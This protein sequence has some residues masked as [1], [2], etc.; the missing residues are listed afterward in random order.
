MR[1]GRKQCPKKAPKEDTKKPHQPRG[2]RLKAAWNTGAK[3]KEKVSQKGS[4]RRHQNATPAPWRTFENI[5]ENRCEMEG[6]S[7]PKRPQRRHQKA[8]PAS[9]RAF[10]SSL[11]NR[12]EILEISTPL[13]RQSNFFLLFV[14]RSSVVRI[15]RKRGPKKGAL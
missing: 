14:S 15:S 10:E 9:W 3:W 6:N 7:V 1:N 12:S 5:L 8:T 4:Q 2:E 13:E 11:E